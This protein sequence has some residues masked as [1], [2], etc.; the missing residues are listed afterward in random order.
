MSV[1]SGAVMSDQ[2]PFPFRPGDMCYIDRDRQ[3]PFSLR[4]VVSVDHGWVRT[5]P[6]GLSS[7][8]AE[9]HG[10]VKSY[11]PR[12]LELHSATFDPKPECDHCGV[13]HD[14][15]AEAEIIDMQ[16]PDYHG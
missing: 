9:V 15:V 5:I 12:E 8:Q 2:E 11:R 13:A 16:S 7:D 6:V 10:L 1:C 4:E 3:V 14:P